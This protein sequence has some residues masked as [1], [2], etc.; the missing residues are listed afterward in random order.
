MAWLTREMSLNLLFDYIGARFT[1][2]HAV[3]Y[4]GKLQDGTVFDSTSSRGKS[5]KFTLGA[6]QGES[7]VC[8]GE[9][10]CDNTAFERTE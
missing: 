8:G 2:L 4:T 5:F 1:T 7:S 10:N 3:N 9:I 6:G